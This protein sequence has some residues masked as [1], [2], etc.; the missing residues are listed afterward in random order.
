MI[1]FLH[2]QDNFRSLQKLKR[3]IIS[4]KQK[5]GG[6]VITIE[7]IDF[8]FGE[9]KNHLQTQGLFKSDK[10][11]VL[12]N[13][14]LEGD[15]NQLNKIDKLLGF[16][17][18]KTSVVFYERDKVDARTAFFKKLTKLA[19]VRGKQYYPEFTLFEPAE[20]RRWIVRELQKSSKTI[21]PQALNFLLDAC[22]NSW[23]AYAEIGKLVVQPQNNITLDKV[24]S[25]VINRIDDNIFHLT[26]AIAQKNLSQALKLLNDQI[27][28]GAQ[29]LYL[30]A[31]I[32]RQIKILIKVKSVQKRLGQ[33]PA[34]QLADTIKEHPFVVQKILSS[35]KLFSLEELTQVYNQILETDLKLKSARISP[36]S[37]LSKLVYD[38]IQ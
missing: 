31:M 30:L 3:A 24:K 21:E 6:D 16:K 17:P 28:N 9:F 19:N 5:K 8:N 10:L 36:Q 14:I 32:A 22:H 29:P 27:K 20:M 23:Q 15:K 26:D 2:G 34:R 12:K 18:A 4:F 1:I 33:I 37:L 25:L 13:L 7:A 11:I 35:A 38:I